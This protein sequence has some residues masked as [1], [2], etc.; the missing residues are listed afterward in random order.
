MKQIHCS[1]PEE[2]RAWLKQNHNREDGIWLVFYKKATGKQSLGYDSALDEALCFGW[3]DSLVRR[4]DEERYAQKFT[5]RKP[6]SKWSAANKRRVEQLAKSKRMTGA[7]CALVKAAK[8]NGWWDRPDRPPAVSRVPREFQAALRR[9]ATARENFDR[10]APSFRKHYVMW[11]AM[12]KRPETKE[13]RIKEAVGLL[14]K[15][16]KLGLR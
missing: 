1:T 11:I 9:N 4:I 5:P 16:E 15:G 14:A 13:K 6:K 2:W 10:L 7:G 12:A 8:A 3:I